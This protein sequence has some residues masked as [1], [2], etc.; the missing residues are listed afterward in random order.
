MRLWRQFHT[1]LRMQIGITS[2]EGNLPISTQLCMH[3]TPIQKSHPG[4]YTE[5]TLPTIQKHMCT[6][7]FII[8]LF[9]ITKSRKSSTCLSIEDWCI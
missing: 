6:K 5:D 2:V 1:L 3:Y 7:L 9:L 4:I 8:A